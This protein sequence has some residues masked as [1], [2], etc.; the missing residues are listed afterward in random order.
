VRVP[1]GASVYQVDQI[2][3]EAGVLPAG[4]FL[5][6]SRTLSS[7]VEGHLFPDTYR[8][9]K[10]SSPG[11]VLKKMRDNFAAKAQPILDRDRP[12]IRENLILA[13]I[14]EKEVPEYEDRQIVAGIMQKR[15]EADMLLQADA[16]LCYMK[17]EKAGAFVPCTPITS[18][19]LKT[20]SPYNTYLSKGLPP[21]PIGSPGL[22]A[23]KAAQDPKES[24]YWYY[25]SDPKTG[26]TIFSKTLD[27]H[28]RNRVKY[29]QSD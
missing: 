9:Y 18:A 21:G 26:K 16:T 1:E 7:E 11:E 15:L 12:H 17:Y 29:L 28:T 13:S 19:D 3:A 6:F 23:I 27:E 24:P 10:N 5:L 14:L 4:T 25:L 22:E 8:F 2:L 20:K